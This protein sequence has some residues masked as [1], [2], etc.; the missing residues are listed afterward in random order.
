MS[1]LIAGP[2]A[3]DTPALSRAELRMWCASLLAYSALQ[4]G[5][6]QAAH[7]NE[8]DG[9]VALLWQGH[10]YLVRITVTNDKGATR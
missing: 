8:V 7:A 4:S 9:T 3:Q 2:Q 5:D 1:A 10:N 6:I